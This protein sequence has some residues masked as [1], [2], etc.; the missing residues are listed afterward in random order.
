MERLNTKRAA[1]LLATLASAGCLRGR[2]GAIPAGP[3]A[4]G[5]EAA[6]HWVAPTAPLQASAKP[7]HTFYV[8][9][10]KGDD[11]ND[12][13]SAETAFRTLARAVA[14]SSAP[15]GPGDRV[16][17]KAGVYRERIAIRK[18]GLPGAPIV[19][20]A[21]GDGEVIVDASAPVTG[22]TAVTGQVYRARPGFK[23]TAVVVDNQPLLPEPDIASLVEGRFH[24]DGAGDLYVW[25]PG[26]G[27]PE[28]HDLGVVRDDEYQEG[29]ALSD[30]SDVTLY[31]LTVRFAG[32]NGISVLGDRVRIEKCRALFNGKAG[33]SV[34]AYGSTPSANVALVGNEM[35]HNVLRN[36]P[37][38]RYK[39][40]GWAMGAVSHGTPGILFEGNVSHRNGG[41]GLGAYAGR[42]GSVFRNNVV[43]DNWSVNIYVDNQPHAVV[44]NNLVYCH[45]PDP[46]D[47]HGNGDPDP[48]DEKSLRRLRAEGIMTA[49][50]KYSLNP[51]A[52]L[53]DVLVANNLVLNCRRGFDHYAQAPGSGLKKV[54]ILHNTIVVP[55]ADGPGEAYVGIRL[56]WNDG[57]N[58]DSVVENNVVYATFRSA[59]L[60]SGGPDVSA[61]DAFVGLRMGHNLWFHARS[62]RP[63]H[64]GPEGPKS[65][66]SHADWAA[67][68]GTSHADGDITDDPRLRDAKSFSPADL[69]PVD[70]SSP[71]VDHG[72]DAGIAMDYA[73]GRRP[74][75]AG[76]DMGALELPAAGGPGGAPPG[77]R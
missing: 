52:N 57:N 71:A 56:P 22:W 65:D 32:G 39:W 54:R 76:F 48:S 17:V 5:P 8:D 62:T 43:Y 29:V 15:V 58:A 10:A 24:L 42:G 13:R 36:W 44:E 26:G 30:A 59:Y 68:P 63:F 77:S 23:V 45:T 55:D 1:I 47:L 70:A 19:V 18:R 9:G 3:L 11:G 60:L 35:Y 6:F 67:L 37:R 2:A 38:G 69:A 74:A 16:L 53:S 21:A 34:F 66:L 72:T 7:P 46:E 73:H 27:S 25:C 4:S 40:G 31:G 61:A 75:G 64:W 20:S 41:E 12:G 28:G 51:P 50:E 14:E 33:I 49:D